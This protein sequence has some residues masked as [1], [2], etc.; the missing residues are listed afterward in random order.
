MHVTA[1]V[2]MQR[3][4]EPHLFL[5]GGARSNRRLLGSI[6]SPEDNHAL[7][8]YSETNPVNMGLAAEEYCKQEL[9]AEARSQL[10]RTAG[11]GSEIDII[12]QSFDVLQTY[13]DITAPSQWENLP[14]PIS[15]A[16]SSN[17]R[18]VFTV[19]P[20]LHEILTYLW[21]A[22]RCW[23]TN[24]KATALQ[25]AQTQ[26]LAL[27]NWIQ[28]NGQLTVCENRIL[29][30]IV[31][32]WRTDALGLGSLPPISVNVAACVRAAGN[33]FTYDGPLWRPE[34]MLGCDGARAALAEALSGDRLQICEVRGPI[35]CGK[36][37]LL[38]TTLSPDIEA[39]RVE[40]ASVKVGQINTQVAAIRGL[41]LAL[42]DEL[43]L[44]Q[45]PDYWTEEK[46]LIDPLRVLEQMIRAICAADRA[47]R[48][49]VIAIDDIEQI[50]MLLAEHD[51]LDNFLGFLF[52][53]AEQI[54]NL[55]IVLLCTV[56]YGHNYESFRSSI[57]RLAN[58][59][60]VTFL[61]TTRNLVIA[62]FLQHPV[63]GFCY[64]FAEKAVDR[65]VELT[66]GQPYLV[67][68]LASGVVQQFVRNQNSGGAGPRL[69]AS[70]FF[71]DPLFT[72]TDIDDAARSE[73]VRQGLRYYKHRMKQH[74]ANSNPDTWP[75]I[76]FILQQYFL[77]LNSKLRPRDLAPLFR[78]IIPVDPSYVGSLMDRLENQGILE[79]SGPDEYSLRVK[80][81]GYR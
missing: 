14:P 31:A 62:E 17:Q 78:T 46:L 55:G 72:D 5:D 15:R 47:S 48:R 2:E 51:E 29:R 61:N 79:K 63:P 4:W 13:L 9:F 56:D 59:S 64:R 41:A 22:R 8:T 49:L 68:L 30:R 3:P 18:E 33:P 34:S 57:S 20:Q 21:L 43:V 60:E 67:Q 28:Q 71:Y 44:I 32:N 16:T 24:T 19:L 36:T 69:S 11:T 26:L 23:N 50:D 39:R 1:L 42:Y 75:H 65:V 76:S 7:L 70:G 66:G 25:T 74:F 35:L 27:E 80:I 53:L 58:P 52:H 37:S 6:F 38:N 54:P 45:R 77:D 10:I 12:A 40:F 81:L 73:P